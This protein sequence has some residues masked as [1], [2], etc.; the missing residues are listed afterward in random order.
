VQTNRTTSTQ[1]STIRQWRQ[2]F[3]EDYNRPAYQFVG[4][5]VIA[6]DLQAIARRIYPSAYSNYVKLF[7]EDGATSVRSLAA[8]DMMPGNPY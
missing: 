1:I 3:L 4:W 7:R 2:M 6:N 5:K 8:W